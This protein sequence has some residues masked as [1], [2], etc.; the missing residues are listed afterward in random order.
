MR[1]LLS[2]FFL[3]SILNGCLRT[4]DDLESGK[5]QGLADSQSFAAE[6]M[7]AQDM[8]MVV[9]Y[10]EPNTIRCNGDRRQICDGTEDWITS[11]ESHKVRS[12][13]L[14]KDRS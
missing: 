2:L 10:C 8:E 4:G 11:S 3:G 1:Y 7:L 13:R 14:I 9:S 6:E 12:P 5:S